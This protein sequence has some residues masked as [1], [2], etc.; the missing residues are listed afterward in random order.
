MSFVESL[1]YKIEQTIMRT[2]LILILCFLIQNNLKGQPRQQKK[3]SSE[4]QI[5]KTL[6][7]FYT[8]YV[9][10]LS[11]LHNE[12]DFEKNQDKVDSILYKYCTLN[13]LSEIR[14][15]LARF[16]QAYYPLLKG[17]SADT[18][19]LKTLTIQKYQNHDDIYSVSYFL[20]NEKTTIKLVITNQRG[21][22]KIDYVWLDWSHDFFEEKISEMLNAFYSNYIRFVSDWT[23]IDSDKVDSLLRKY[24]T[25]DLL[26]QREDASD[27]DPFLKTEKSDIRMLDN[28]K[29]E[30]DSVHNDIYFVSYFLGNRKT[31]IKLIIVNRSGH[32][33]I[34]YLW[35]G[36]N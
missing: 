20:K 33:M 34:D 11:A 8:S 12:G 16:D 4:E 2:F 1:D 6:Q 30:K 24:C 22:Y 13:L 9:T 3:N 17:Y 14:F 36:V 15:T 10:R 27:Y 21:H 31:T 25:I 23:A 26:K 32:Y 35:I 29:V 18:Q 7:T 5:T 28:L 19:V